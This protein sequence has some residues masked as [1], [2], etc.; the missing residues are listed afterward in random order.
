VAH[1]RSTWQHHC[2][3]PTPPPGHSRCRRLPEKGR[4]WPPL[5]PSTARPVFMGQV[6]S[7]PTAPAAESSPPA[8][9]P[10]S[11]SPAP[12]SSSLEALA[13]GMCYELDFLI[14]WVGGD[15]LIRTL[16]VA[17]VI[18]LRGLKTLVLDG[19]LLEV[20]HTF[21]PVVLGFCDNLCYPVM[22]ISCPNV[23]SLVQFHWCSR[24]QYCSCRPILYPDILG[25]SIYYNTLYS[26]M[27]IS[28]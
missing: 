4:G 15:S 11:P 1:H 6:E 10:S 20:C 14:L 21:R 24:L 9:E 7:Q 3:R 26:F 12:A 23:G 8:E 28:C 18:G 13:A 19:A 2:N 22:Y 25:F 16:W 27:L 5:A 17:A